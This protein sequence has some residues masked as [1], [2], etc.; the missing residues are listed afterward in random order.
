MGEDISPKEII[1]HL[2][3]LC[4]EKG[5]KYVTIPTK[6]ELG[7]AAGI[8]KP[9]SSVAIISAGEGDGKELLMKVM[10]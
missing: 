6:A 7:A 10:K 4:K 8:G 5:I 2:P 3:I 1:A 9:C